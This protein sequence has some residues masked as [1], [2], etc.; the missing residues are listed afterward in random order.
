M[1]VVTIAT[2]LDNAFLKDILIRSC[3]NLGLELVILRPRAWE[4]FATK[5]HVLEA[6]LA[7]LGAPQLDELIL[8][9]DAYDAMFIRGAEY[10]LEQYE[11]LGHPILFSAEYNCWP[12]GPLGFAIYGPAAPEPMRY[13]NSGGFI[14]R[15]RDILAL[16]RKYPEA[17]SEAFESLRMLR[18]HG[19]DLRE[20]AFSDQYWW[21]LVH[22]LERELVGLD[23]GQRVFD[24]STPKFLNLLRRDIIAKVLDAE[25]QGPGS[26]LHVRERRRLATRFA[27][28]S[29]AA[30]LHFAGSVT[31]AVVKDMHERGEL[32]SWV[33]DA[34]RA[35]APIPDGTVTIIES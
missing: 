20:F 19:F 11:R 34:L 4:N 35:D 33:T 31:K 7:S 13:L 8:F 21:T 3:A 28:P 5:K 29:G 14:G 30:H 1:R 23:R 27:T 22:L 16:Q 2:D 15:G 18:S 6:Y 32:P 9:T 10:V 17:P 26:P 12:L 24:C 25:R